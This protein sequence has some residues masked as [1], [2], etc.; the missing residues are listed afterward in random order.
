M[1]TKEGSTKIVNFMTPGEGVLV[2]VLGHK[3]HCSKYALS[4][5]SALS[6]DSTLIAIVL[7]NY[8][9]AFLRHC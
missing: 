3:R 8:N 2:L 9:A 5:T 4:S 1:K 7:R 6:I